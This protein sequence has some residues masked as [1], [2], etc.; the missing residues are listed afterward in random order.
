MIWMGIDRLAVFLGARTEWGGSGCARI[1]G[2]ASL[3]AGVRCRQKVGRVRAWP[4]QCGL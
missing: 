2:A 4:A 1:E 3:V